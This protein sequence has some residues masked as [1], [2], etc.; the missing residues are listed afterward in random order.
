V[1]GPAAL[2]PDGN[3][4]VLTADDQTIIVDTSALDITLLHSRSE[5]VGEHVRLGE[6]SAPRVPSSS[7]TCCW[8]TMVTC[9]R[10]RW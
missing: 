7:C 10:S 5:P 4:W 9:R 2:D 3:P 6:I 1:I 8:T